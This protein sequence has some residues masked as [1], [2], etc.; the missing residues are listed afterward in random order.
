M[1]LTQEEKR[2][3][4]SNVQLKYKDYLDSNK[5]NIK[6]KL[7]KI[8]KQSDVY[9]NIAN[10]LKNKFT[11]FD[12]NKFEINLDWD[13]YYTFLSINYVDY[14]TIQI[15]DKIKNGYRFDYHYNID[16][17]SIGDLY[18]ITEDSVSRFG[19]VYIKEFIKCK[20]VKLAGVLTRL[21]VIESVITTLYNK[22]VVQAEQLIESFTL[23]DNA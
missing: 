1:V 9:K 7:I 14:G 10:F 19:N 21:N 3:I 23:E 20:D 11:D 8:V 5:I 13:R 6:N 12:E 18:Y 4:I 17:L 16:T 15:N 2:Y 22:A